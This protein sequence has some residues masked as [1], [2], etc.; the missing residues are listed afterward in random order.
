GNPSMFEGNTFLP[1]QGMPIACNARS[2]TRLADWL[3]D[4]L[5]VPTRIARS[6]TVAAVGVGGVMASARGGDSTAV[7]GDGMVLLRETWARRSCPRNASGVLVSDP[8]GNN[9]DAASRTVHALTHLQSNTRTRRSQARCPFPGRARPS[10]DT[11]NPRFPG[12]W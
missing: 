1:L 7:S 3:P 2:R 4:P 12:L 11:Q 5:T 10:G 6:L 9:G 8:R